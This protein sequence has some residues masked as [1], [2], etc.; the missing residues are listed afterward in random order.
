MSSLPNI[1]GEKA[2]LILEKYQTPLKA[3]NNIED[4]PKKVHGLGPIIS[5]KVKEV[6]NTQYNKE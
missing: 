3:F 5:N 1:G 2:K 6:M 4:W